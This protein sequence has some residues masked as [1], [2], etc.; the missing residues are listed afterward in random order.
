M[1]ICD[2]CCEYMNIEMI[3]GVHCPYKK[4]LEFNKQ[5]AANGNT[6]NIDL[7]LKALKIM[8]NRV[9]IADINGVSNK[10]LIFII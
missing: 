1:T 9:T 2:Y 6:D 4:S 10:F 7:K 3:E 8:E 5:D